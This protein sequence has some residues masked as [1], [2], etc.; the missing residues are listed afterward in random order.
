MFLKYE[1]V[2]PIANRG[3]QRLLES[4]QS[5]D[6]MEAICGYNTPPRNEKNDQTLINLSFPKK[7]MDS[8][9]NPHL[10]RRSMH[11]IESMRSVS[12]WHIELM[13]SMETMEPI[14]H[15]V[16][17]YASFTEPPDQ[18]A[19][20]LRKKAPEFM[21][22]RNLARRTARSAYN[23]KISKPGLF[24]FKQN[25]ML[26]LRLLVSSNGNYQAV[27]TRR[28][29]SKNGI[30]KSQALQFQSFTSLRSN[31]LPN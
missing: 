11:S 15:H 22:F 13:E 7:T 1:N 5:L 19:P 21:P 26:T 30:T 14:R 4:M 17:M 16:Y 29:R 27:R 18:R 3:F 6:S 8:P 20:R 12:P 24:V 10:A 9:R 31:Y 23:N 25:K 28:F 2:K